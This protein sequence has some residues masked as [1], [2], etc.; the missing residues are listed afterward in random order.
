MENAKLLPILKD[1]FDLVVLIEDQE[2]EC[3]KQIK[4]LEANKKKLKE[5]QR[6]IEGHKIIDNQAEV[7][8]SGP[9]YAKELFKTIMCPLLDKCPND[10]RP[11]WHKSGERTTTPF[12]KKCPYAHHYM[13]LEFPQTLK[14]KIS[15]ISKMKKSVHSQIESARPGKAFIPTGTITDCKGGCFTSKCNQCKYKSMAG[16]IITNL[17]DTSIRPSGEALAKKTVSAKARINAESSEN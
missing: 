11:R 2:K 8:H 9:N 17:D 16:Y 6:Q 3:H 5:K 15:S 7:C 4:K 14:T 13:E 1:A 10:C 12:G